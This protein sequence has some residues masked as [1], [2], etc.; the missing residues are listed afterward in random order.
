MQPGKD[1]SF[2]KFRLD[3]ANER[4]MQGS[5]AIPLR[6]KAF[7]VLKLLVESSGQLVTK[8][9]LLD[10]VWPGTFVSEAV[11]KDS[12]RQLREALNDSAES[13]SYIETAHRRGYRFI[14]HVSGSALAVKQ[15]TGGPHWDPS[16]SQNEITDVSSFPISG[17]L[18]R[19]AELGK[20][21]GWLKQALSHERRVVFVTGE[22]GIGKTTLVEALLQQAG[23]TPGISIARGQCLEHYGAGEAYMPVLDAFSR[24]SRSPSGALIVD[25]LRHHAPAWLAQMASLVPATERATLQTHTTGATRERMLREM[26]EAVEAITGEVPLILVLEDLHWSDYSTLDLVSYLARRR[27]PA[28]LMLIGTYRPVE[29]ILEDHPLKEVKRELQAHGLCRELP[30]EYLTDEAIA[31]YL[32]TRFPGHKF[33]R[34]LSKV[35]HRR[36]E[37]NPLFM[38]NVLEYLVEEK[39]I[40]EEHG[41]WELRVDWSQLELGVPVSLRQLIEKQIERLSPDERTVLEGASVVGMECS[42]VAIA[43]GLDKSTEWVEQHC[44]ELARRHQFLSPAWLVELPDGTITPR[45]KF[46][47]ILYLEVPYS[48]IPPLRRAQIHH[49]IAE[50][51]V[52]VYGDQVSLIAAELAMHFEQSR[53]WPLALQYL[54][55]SAEN[56]SHRSAHHEAADLAVRGLTV[57]K[58]LPDAPE[59][60]QQEIALRMSLGVSLMAMKGF[61][62]T[63]VEEV[64]ARARELCWLQGPSPQLFHMLWSL[65]LYYIFSGEMD[66]ALEIANQLLQ[67]A[68]GIQDSPLIMEAHRAMGVTLLDLGRC[69]EALEHLEQATSLYA[70]HR[71]HP[72]TVWIGHDCKVVCECFAARALWALGH[73]DEA[74]AKIAGALALARELN[75]PQTSVLVG[76]FA[77]QIHQLTG[78][79]SLAYEHAK[80]VVD[81]ADEYGLEL[82]L[83]F[84]NID[85]GW[86]EVA[87]AQ[88]ETG[89]ERMR[90]G[91]AAYETTGARLWRPYFLGLLATALATAQQ[92][93]EALKVVAD[94]IAIAERTREMYSIAELYRIRGHVLIMRAAKSQV[95]MSDRIHKSTTKERATPRDHTLSPDLAEASQLLNQA[96]ALARQQ[97]ARSWELRTMATLNRLQHEGS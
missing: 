97:Q 21:R 37:G 40:V 75:H 87:Q 73:T 45:H 34:R 32:S 35:I 92:F 84:G 93:E 65:G 30:L 96:L 19:E 46:N 33:S 49:R 79:I 31:D 38:V 85:L 3:L 41:S 9:Q 23:A 26:A 17:V 56:A 61:A 1:I 81:L 29:V 28:R 58:S 15:Q 11:L 6:P 5:R 82:W 95:T 94:A 48:M 78:E 83:A 53:D 76:H 57:L 52:A 22:A 10:A 51:G 7:A 70:T 88:V 67:L 20:M 64:Y 55:Q 86:A 68:E 13:P 24:L 14:A 62:A 16:K 47:H 80:E 90:R 43:A 91:L 2:A 44:E 18:G 77:A 8:Q 60:A 89:I 72:Y 36:T 69:A 63:E 4:L 25:M 12:I 71:N 74:V 27:D 42:S 50:R 59:R 54:T 39:I 66:S